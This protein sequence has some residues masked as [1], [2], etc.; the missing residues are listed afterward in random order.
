MVPGMRAHVPQ[1]P[2]GHLR[3]VSHTPGRTY[4]GTTSITRRIRRER[5]K[6]KVAASSKIAE[7]SLKRSYTR[8]TAVLVYI[9]CSYAR[10]YIYSSL[11]AAQ[12]I[13]TYVGYTAVVAPTLSKS[14][15]LVLFSACCLSIQ[16][17]LLSAPIIYDM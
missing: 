6:V 13:Y 9:S 5:Q 11:P 10:I 12:L 16:L 1:L 3:L 4:F 7:P 8:E 17:G 2:V 15:R 14:V